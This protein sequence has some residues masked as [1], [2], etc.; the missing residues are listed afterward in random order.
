MGW[1]GEGER[2]IKRKGRK[3]RER[4]HLLSRF[5]GDRISGFRRSKRESS[6]SLQ[7][8]RIETEVVEFRKTL[9]VRSVLLL[10]YSG[11]KCHEK[12]GFGSCEAEN[13]RLFQSQRNGTKCLM[14]GLSLDSPRRPE[15]ILD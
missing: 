13:D 10:G 5:P 14:R 15:L 7:G 12:N 4:H 2:N 9:K 11:L 6:S 3:K 8:L 1:R